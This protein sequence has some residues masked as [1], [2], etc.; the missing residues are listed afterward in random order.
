MV[1]HDVVLYTRP[2]C[3]LCDTAKELLAKYAIYPREVN[4]D[5]DVNLQKAYGECV[6][7][8]L[9]DGKV[10]FRGRVDEVLLKRLLSRA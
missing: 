10:R 1:D 6:P 3:H 9:M 4:V 5:E 7:V 8:V 2:E